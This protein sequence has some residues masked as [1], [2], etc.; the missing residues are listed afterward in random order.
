[1]KKILFIFIG[2]F[3][4]FS[5]CNISEPYAGFYIYEY[6]IE[7]FTEIT[8]YNESRDADEYLWDFG[9]GTTST[10]IDPTHNYSDTGS[11]TISLT[12][13]NNNKSESDILQK[14]IFVRY[15]SVFMYA[16]ETLSYPDLHLD[17]TAIP[18]DAT[19]TFKI[20]YKGNAIYTFWGYITD[21]FNNGVYININDQNSFDR[22]DFKFEN[23]TETHMLEIWTSNAPVFDNVLD[24]V[25]LIPYETSK[26]LQRPLTI[27]SARGTEAFIYFR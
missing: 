8:F 3:A 20:Y 16:L 5:S 27:S 6:Q 14:T 13:Y 26:G 24:T 2:L 10:E 12:A 22:L 23:K 19:I 17:N 15:P 25:Q 4:L 21:E 11:Y 9:D 1:M 18:N 7:P